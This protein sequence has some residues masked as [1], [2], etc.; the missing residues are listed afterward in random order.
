MI[1]GGF[2]FGPKP[3]LWD[4]WFLV[5]AASWLRVCDVA[6]LTQGLPSEPQVLLRPE[7]RLMPFLVLLSAA[8]ALAAGVGVDGGAVTVSGLVV[9][10]VA[11]TSKN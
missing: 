8:L 2:E 10:P 7:L 4:E 5:Y 6:T 1:F 3:D 9:E 11:S